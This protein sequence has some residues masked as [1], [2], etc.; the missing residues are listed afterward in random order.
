MKSINKFIPA[1]ILMTIVLILNGYILCGTDDFAWGVTPSPSASASSTVSPFLASS[2]QT[3]PT[4][5]P[6]DANPQ[7]FLWL[8]IGGLGI[9]S[10]LLSFLTFR[11]I[12]WCDEKI[13]KIDQRT[14][15]L[16]TKD[17]ALDQRIN[18]R[19]TS[20]DE[21]KKELSFYKKTLDTLQ[22]QDQQKFISPDR[23]D[24][25]KKVTP[26][27]YSYSQPTTQ[28]NY[29]EQGLYPQSLPK[30]SEPWSIIA[31]NYNNDSVTI[32]SSAQGVSETED[33][34]YRRR[35][36]SSIKLVTLQ[37]VSNYSYWVIADSEGGYW[38]TPIAELK[39][40]P[41]NFDTF[42]A[43]FQFNG[44]PLSGKLQLI[45]PAKVTQAPTGQWE[46][47]DRGEVQFI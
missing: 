14:R 30:I 34:I 11:T 33:S 35:R 47:G 23:P 42:Q 15:E 12:K 43:L 3:S 31:Q 46:L 10:L 28:D 18:R 38:L 40:N 36:D 32:S 17:A 21:L 6:G 5:E 25:H 13:S 20:I 2:G 45:K 27:D 39:L 19:S 8:A 29:A 1:R 24:F 41:M 44:E 4:P 7:L 16:G 37:S 26:Y 22:L 9:W